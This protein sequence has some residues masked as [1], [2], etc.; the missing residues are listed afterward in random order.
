MPQQRHQRQ[1]HY[2]F[3]FKL[4]LTSYY[5]LI[6]VSVYDFLF[7]HTFTKQSYYFG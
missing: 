6:N 4:L 7:I 5:H 2:C 3:H 1:F